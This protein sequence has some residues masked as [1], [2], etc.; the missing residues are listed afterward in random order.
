MWCVKIVIRPKQCTW[1]RLLCSNRIHVLSIVGCHDSHVGL[2]E[3]SFTNSETQTRLH[4]DGLPRSHQASV[5]PGVCQAIFASSAMVA[6]NVAQQCRSHPGTHNTNAAVASTTEVY[7]ASRQKCTLNQRQ[8]RRTGF[9]TAPALPA[10]RTYD[11]IARQRVLQ[12]R[13][14]NMRA[15]LLLLLLMIFHSVNAS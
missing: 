2:L 6:A 3:T 12:S 14:S 1:I 9:A 5:I 8:A 13:G 15:V 10:D 4:I 11:S 7:F